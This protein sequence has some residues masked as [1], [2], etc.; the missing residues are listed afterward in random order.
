MYRLDDWHK[1]LKMRNDF[2]RKETVIPVL[3]Q[4]SKKH[5]FCSVQL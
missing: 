5:R 1:N 2:G 4:L 3:K